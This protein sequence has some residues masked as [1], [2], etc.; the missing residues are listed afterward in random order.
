MRTGQVMDQAVKQALDVGRQLFFLLQRQLGIG[1]E[2]VLHWECTA[3]PK[4][5]FKP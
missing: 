3:S 2:L 4:A 1:L 5:K